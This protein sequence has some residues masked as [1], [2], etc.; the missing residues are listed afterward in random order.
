MSNKAVFL[1][2]DGVL[3]QEIGN[4]VWHPEQFVVLP[5]VPESLA[6]LKAAGYILIVVTNQAG[7]AKGLYTAADV[8]ACHQKLQQACHGA[9]DALYFA[10]GHP[11][12]SES[13]RR[14]PDSLMLEQAMARFHLDAARCWLV[15]DRLRDMQAGAKV[16]VRGILVGAEEAAVF[17]PRVPDLAAAA[18]LILHEA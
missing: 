12:V 2:R 9:L 18:D 11:S 15:G 3:N 1:D 17:Q 6:R 14:K 8:R 16:G 10:P 4:Y 13:L 5:G 7:I